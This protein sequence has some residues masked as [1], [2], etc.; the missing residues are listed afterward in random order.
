MHSVFQW[1]CNVKSKVNITC[2]YLGQPFDAD[3]SIVI[4]IRTHN[5]Y[6]RMEIVRNSSEHAASYTFTEDSC[7]IVN[8][9]TDVVL[10]NDNKVQH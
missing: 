2:V 3:G 8:E 9:N 4:I 1:S 7:K 6:A 10:P 5:N